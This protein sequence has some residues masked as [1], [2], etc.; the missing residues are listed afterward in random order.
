V[1]GTRRRDE[2]FLQWKGWDVFFRIRFIDDEDGI[3][4]R[5]LSV[6]SIRSHGGSGRIRAHLGQMS[7]SLPFSSDRMMVAACIIKPLFDEPVPCKTDD[8]SV[9]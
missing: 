2:P 8:I 1:T 5:C 3:H 6:I 7:F 9:S 4:Q